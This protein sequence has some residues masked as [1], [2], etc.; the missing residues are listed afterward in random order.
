MDTFIELIKKLDVGQ[1]I[2]MGCM[3]WFFYSRI[4]KKFDKLEAKIEDRFDKIEQRMDKMEQRMDR[5]EALVNNLD[6]RLFV[7]EA[8]LQMKGC[9][10]ITDDK[11]LRKAE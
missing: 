3:L 6:K 1:L 7:V 2:V 4:E 11:H 5:I 8:I 10:A 9:C